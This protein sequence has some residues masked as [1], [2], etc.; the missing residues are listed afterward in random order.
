MTLSSPP[1]YVAART[2]LLDAL[3]ALEPQ[4]DS[5]VL[6][7]AQAIY[8]R[9]DPD[10]S[11]GVATTT[12]ADV[13]LDTDLLSDDPEL[14]AALE[15][16][17]FTQ[18]LNPGSWI[19]Q[20]GVAVD[21]M[22]A[23]HQAG[24]DKAGARGAKLP[25]HGKWLARITPGLE[26]T[27][28]DHAPMQIVA[29]NPSDTRT[30]TI[31]VAGPASLLVAKAFKIAERAAASGRSRLRTKDAVD[32]LRLLRSTEPTDMLDGLQS[33][34]DTSSAA[35][36]SRQALEFLARQRALGDTDVVRSLVADELDDVAAASYGALVDELLADCSGGGLL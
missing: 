10:T 14:T 27:L 6:V 22:V 23:P 16:A 12:D 25:P 3:E 1:E 33:H 20:G 29:L 7:G 28:V 17:G 36:V 11:T 5:L 26:A 15:S 24:T 4:R 13:A 2:V 34:A 32:I 31:E 21:I 9:T 30:V 18:G 35:Y 8:M 19:G